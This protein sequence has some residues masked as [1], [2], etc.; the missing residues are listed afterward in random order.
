MQ[1]ISAD[2]P[3][4]L[5]PVIKAWESLPDAVKTGILAMVKAV[6]EK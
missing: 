1:Q 2:K 4:D 3:P 6:L 5:M